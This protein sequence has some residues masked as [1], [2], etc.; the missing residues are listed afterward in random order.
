[1]VFEVCLQSVDGAIA[2]EKGGA[3]RVE[4]CAALIEGGITPS[5]GT[6]EACKKAVDI[7]IM[8]MIRPRGGDFAY[9]AHELAVMERDI[10]ACKQIGVTGVV[11]G[12]LNPDGSVAR[13]QVQRLVQVAAGMD[14]CFHRAFDVCA[15]PF[16]ALE[17]LID[18][19]VTRI[20]T[21]GQRGIVPEGQQLIK[22]LVERAA[23]RIE[24]LPGCGITPENVAEVVAYTGV[25]QF[26][27][28]AF[29][30]VES[31][32]QHQNPNVY[33]GLPGLPEYEREMTSEAE[34][35]RFL[36]AL[37]QPPFSSNYALP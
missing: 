32:M 8:V 1:M 36:A 13:P 14:V 26:H 22:A 7:D 10:M 9:T 17:E 37:Q 27:A 19:G 18:L 29:G 33:M 16:V 34:V 21:S 30:R 20:L 2:A 5:L 25:N 28:T 12:M 31:Q 4:L 24:I 23:G 35:R 11:F 3:K 6:V 15:D